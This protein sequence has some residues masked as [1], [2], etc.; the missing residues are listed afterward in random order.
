VLR[1]ATDASLVDVSAHLRD[2]QLEVS[3]TNNGGNTTS[4]LPSSGF[5]LTG[6]TERVADAG[7]RLSAGPA[8]PG[9]RVTATLP[10]ST[11]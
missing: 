5:G 1:H 8:D 3:V 4:G 10:S 9:W 6:L 11:A 2:G 7:G